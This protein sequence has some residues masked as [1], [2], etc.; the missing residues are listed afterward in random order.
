MRCLNSKSEAAAICLSRVAMAL[1]SHPDGNLDVFLRLHVALELKCE[2]VPYAAA[3]IM[4][5]S[6]DLRA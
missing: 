5:L 4:H 3:R 6:R 2:K 1:D